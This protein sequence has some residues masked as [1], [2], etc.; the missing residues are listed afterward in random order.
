MNEEQRRQARIIQETSEEIGMMKGF[1]VG[2]VVT[3]SFWALALV[4]VGVV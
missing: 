2:V 1:A 4:I 3:S